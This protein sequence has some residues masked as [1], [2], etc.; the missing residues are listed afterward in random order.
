MR[1]RYSS[2]IRTILLALACA[3]LI[4][5]ASQ[6]AQDV[7]SEY[8]SSSEVSPYGAVSVVRMSTGLVE[9]GPK[10]LVYAPSGAMRNL[11]F[12]ENVW[13]LGYRTSIVDGNGRPPEEN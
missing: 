5:P 8:V 13:V 7:L 1:R 6:P 4:R 11:Q 2:R 3:G 9:L 12:S 10:I